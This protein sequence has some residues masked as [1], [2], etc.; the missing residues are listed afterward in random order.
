MY[1]YDI[2]MCAYQNDALEVFY[3]CLRKLKTS[4]CNSISFWVLKKSMFVY[5]PVK[6]KK[7]L[8][9][10]RLEFEQ[11]GWTIVDFMSLF[12]LLCIF[13]FFQLKAFLKA[14]LS[15]NSPSN[16]SSISSHCWQNKGSHL[17]L[18]ESTSSPANIL[19][20]ILLLRAKTSTT[21]RMHE[22]CQAFVASFL[23]SIQ[24]G[25]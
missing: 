17:L 6:K 13:W 15:C 24:P 9:S 3:W 8:V 12:L 21:P 10:D 4:V 22:P 14:D 11:W 2:L 18:M 5:V 19:P 20:L 7:T 25:M 23:H 16:N 1:W